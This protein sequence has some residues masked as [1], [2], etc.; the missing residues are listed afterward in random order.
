MRRMVVVMLLMTALSFVGFELVIRD[1]GSVLLGRTLVVNLIVMCG[2]F[3]MLSCR[4][5]DKSVLTTGIRGNRP[6]F[7]GAVGMI[8]LQ[9]I[10]TYT[11]WFKLMFNTELMPLQYWGVAVL[12]GVIV[13]LAV[14][15]EKFFVRKKLKNSR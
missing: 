14:E 4:S 6:M 7:W 13:M 2:I 11:P 3:L 15:T 9:I 10:F 5:W 8:V 12:S 1:G